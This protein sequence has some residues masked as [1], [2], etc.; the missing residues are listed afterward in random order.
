MVSMWWVLQPPP[1]EHTGSSA[2][3]WA[4][5]VIAGLAWVVFMCLK[6]QIRPINKCEKCPKPDADGNRKRCRKCGDKSEV[7]NRWAYLQAKAGIPVPRARRL[8]DVRHP[9]AVPKDW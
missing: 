2:A 8:P 4:F 1:G 9:R 6:A 3:G 5:L 7:L